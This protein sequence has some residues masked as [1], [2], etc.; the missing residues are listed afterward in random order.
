MNPIGFPFLAGRTVILRISPGLMD[1]L[2]DPLPG[3][4]LVDAVVSTHSVTDPSAFG[5]ARK[6]SSADS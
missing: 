5:T 2:F 3:Q 1:E 4:H 6:I